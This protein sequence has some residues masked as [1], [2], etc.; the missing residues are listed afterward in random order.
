MFHL[1]AE[2]TVNLLENIKFISKGHI[3]KK[4]I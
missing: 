4:N 2:K 1:N 3:S